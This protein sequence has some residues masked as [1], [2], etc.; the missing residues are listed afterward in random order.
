MRTSQDFMQTL[1]ALRPPERTLKLAKRVGAVGSVALVSYVLWKSGRG[2]DVS[3]LR[4]LPLLGAL[5]ASLVA[6]LGL[7]TGWTSLSP[8]PTRRR[9]LSIW[10]RS[11]ALRY[12]PGVGWAQ[13]A[14]APTVKAKTLGKVSS[15][16]VEAAATVAV[17]LAVGGGLYAW[18]HG[19]VWYAGLAAPVAVAAVTA[20]VGQ[21]LGFPPRRVFGATACY[22]VSWAAYGLAAIWSQAA[23]GGAAPPLEIAGAA[24]LAWAFGFLTV[25]TPGGMGAR[26]VAYVALLS[27]VLP[28]AQLAGAALVNRVTYTVAELAVLMVVV[29][30][31]RRSS[32]AQ[33]SLS[34]GRAGQLQPIRVPEPDPVPPLSQTS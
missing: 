34:P 18:W 29:V 20:I 25:I 23:V 1:R 10:S 3:T 14:R 21:K 7:A 6:W 22:L 4:P 9:S 5:G 15:V 2:L 11:Q 30:A 31:E 17:A 26:E 8:L 12:L 13:A 32:S 16:F 28:Q 19:P 24:C 33:P 27:S